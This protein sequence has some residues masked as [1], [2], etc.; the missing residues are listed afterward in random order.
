MYYSKIIAL[1]SL[2]HITSLI[3]T[4]FMLVKVVNCH[5]ESSSR[6]TVFCPLADLTGRTESSALPTLLDW[7]GAIWAR[8]RGLVW[9]VWFVKGVLNLDKYG[10]LKFNLVG[11]LTIG[12][13]CCGLYVLGSSQNTST[14]FNLPHK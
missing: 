11:S 5:N 14:I 12:W 1:L 3:I 6:S 13:L 9:P 7:G 2:V 10:L 8:L 4:M